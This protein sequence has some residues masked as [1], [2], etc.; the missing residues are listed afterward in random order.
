MEVTRIHT[1]AVASGL[2]AMRFLDRA[3]KA[4]PAP[5]GPE[6]RQ[7]LVGHSSELIA[8][9]VASVLRRSRSLVVSTWDHRTHDTAKHG[10][11]DLVVG[12][13]AHLCRLLWPDAGASD[14]SAGLPQII[15]LAGAA[16]RD[17]ALP[18]ELR[19][20]SRRLPVDSREEDLLAAVADANPLD[21]DWMP[22]VARRP[23]G[24]LAPGAL[25][26]VKESVEAR[27]AESLSLRS[28]AGIAG[29]SECHFSRA[30]KQSVGMPPHRYVNTRR[31]HVASALVRDTDR[32]LTDIALEVGFFDH[33]HFTR[34]FVRVTGETPRAHRRRHR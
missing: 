27:I 13:A 5:A 23:S 31:I 28:L 9:G 30:F 15:W 4:A 24:G 26:R 25:R 10:G 17:A 22:A 19:A 33:S 29:L 8:A 11:I 12:D 1:Q 16:E 2:D 6:L 34:M 18:Y 21:D 20:I 32:A 14:A 3:A 7:V